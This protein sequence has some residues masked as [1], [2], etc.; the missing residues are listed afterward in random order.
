MRRFSLKRGRPDASEKRRIKYTLR[1]GPFRRVSEFDFSF[2]RSY[3]Y[4]V[5]YLSGEKDGDAV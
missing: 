4:I 1:A 5:Y 3:N 2:F